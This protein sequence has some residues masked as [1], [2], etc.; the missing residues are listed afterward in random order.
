MHL[1]S[2]NNSHFFCKLSYVFFWNIEIAVQVLMLVNWFSGKILLA[3]NINLT[4]LLIG[5]QQSSQSEAMLPNS[6]FNF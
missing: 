4:L 6:N 1:I 2:Y 3:N 5:W